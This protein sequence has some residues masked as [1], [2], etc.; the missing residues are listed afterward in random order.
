MNSEC[1]FIF[2]VDQLVLICVD[3]LMPTF[4]SLSTALTFYFQRTISNPEILHKIQTEIDSVVGR[5]RLPTLN[6]RVQ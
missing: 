6:D 3:F 2:I 1:D 5:S 4:G